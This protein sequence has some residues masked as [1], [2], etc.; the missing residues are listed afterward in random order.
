[1]A[2]TTSFGDSNSGL[3]AAIINGNVTAQF[4]QSTSLN[5]ACLR[6]LRTTHPPD[7]KDR[8]QT[9]NGGLLRDSYSW[10]LDNEEFKQWQ[11]S[12]E[13][14]LLWIRG[15][16]GKGKTMLLCGIIDELARLNGESS[17]ISFFL[18]QAADIR[19]N[20][21]TAVLRGL[22]Y[23][24]VVNQPCLLA[25]VRSRYD[26]AG[27]TLFEDVNAWSAL[28]AIFKNILNDPLLKDT[29]LIIDALDECITGLRSLLDFIVQYS[30]VHPQI[31][32]IVSSRNW[33]EITERLYIA[34]QVAPISLEL[35]EAS[36]SEAVKKYVYHKVDILA[37][38]K[39]YNDN[40]RERVCRHLLLNSQ[41][42][43]LWVALVYQN[44]DRTPPRYA[45]KKLEAFPPGLDALYSRMLNQVRK[46]EDA[47][48]C[49]QI[50]AIMSTVYRPI[51]LY[52][53]ASVIE[54][55]E[56]SYD[57]K[58]CLSEI[59]A[60]CGSFLS[61]R[62]DTV[63]FVHQSAKEFLLREESLAEILPKGIDA[64]HHSIF[65]RSVD[66]IFKTLRRD[67]LN[68]KL[69]GFL[70]KDIKRPI[71]YPLA[72]A[73]YACVYWVDHLQASKSEATYRLSPA[74]RN[75]VDTFLRQ[76]YLHWLEALSIFARLSDGIQAMRRL[77]ILIE[78]ASD[79]QTVKIWDT[80]TG[81]IVSTIG[82][83]ASVTSIA[84]SQDGSRLASASYDKTVR[85]WNPATSQ[86]LS[87]L[88]GHSLPVSLITWSP[89]GSRLASASFD[90]TV[91]IWDPVTG[92]SIFTLE[93]HSDCVNLVAWSQ[94]GT[95]L[96]S[97]SADKTV[98]IWDPATGQSISILKGHNDWI[99]S[100]YWSQDG[101]RLASGSADQTVRIWDPVTGKSI[102]TLKGHTYSVTSIA[103]SLDSS[104][105]A[106]ASND[107]TVRIWDP[108]TGQ[109]LSILEGHTESVTSIAWSLDRNRLASA[110]NDK[111]IKIWNTATGRG[112]STLHTGFTAFLHFDK[113]HF[114]RLHTS[115]GIFELGPIGSATP[116]PQDLSSLTKRYGYGL[117]HDFSW[118]T[119]RGDKLLWLPI[120]Y[121]PFF[122]S[123]FA[124]SA[125]GLA[126]ACSSGQVIFL[127]LSEP[128]PIPAL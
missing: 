91:K 119:Y 38:V 78:A 116:P 83:T 110:S 40:V 39:R 45:L 76:K 1:M 9:T 21:A 24:L 13:S 17:N 81:Q 7:D 26:Q 82:H 93:G 28:L 102:Y 112:L 50:L 35:N 118:V 16:P 8:I 121:R 97:V 23:L 98:R 14:P 128:T 49:K 51:T 84:W 122:L 100:I 25:H 67:I 63:A 75:R 72:A 19:I 113:A 10:I 66:M 111:T 3:Q 56:D 6:D 29:Y 5:Q 47:E 54:M 85:I 94:D 73:E 61:L 70:A 79:D 41:D 95:Q 32:W 22:I 88:R 2:S 33:P 87:T 58:E 15:D 109:I 126:V 104:Q 106:S 90:E 114:N 92:Q 4:E 99:N 20:S 52:E 103:W 86:S 46:S 69:P 57:A 124:I 127:A 89:D 64:E 44:L 30:P 77:E 108:A 107:K 74:D 43:F 36:V 120:E 125:T 18:C 12:R 37:N 31:K 117:S 59:V 115:L 105:L 80:T 55:P 60:F 42:T 123:S 34:A 96:A 62:E 68:I 71:P 65:A 48:L 53:L 11:D 27:K 101:T